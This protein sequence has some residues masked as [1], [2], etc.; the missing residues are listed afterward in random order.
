MQQIGHFR[1]ATRFKVIGSMLATPKRGAS[2]KQAHQT[3]NTRINPAIHHL[4]RHHQP[5]ALGWFPKLLPTIA[6]EGFTLQGSLTQ[7][8]PKPSDRDVRDLPCRHA[9][10]SS[11]WE[12]MN[13]LA[14]FQKQGIP[15][16]SLQAPW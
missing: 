7:P 3:I 8:S 1:Y 5:V 15:T 13:G 10:I 11:V 4:R 6:L 16:L 2:S 14:S 9:P 12:D